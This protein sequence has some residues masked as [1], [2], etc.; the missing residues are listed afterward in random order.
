MNDDPTRVM[1]EDDGGQDNY[2]PGPEDQ[3]KHLRYLIVGLIAVIVGLVFAVIVIS[4]GD[5]TNSEPTGTTGTTTVEPS[6]TTGP[7]GV[8][9]VTPTGPT[10]DTSTTGDDPSGGV[11]PPADTGTPSTE[12]ST[13]GVVPETD[14]GSGSA[15]GG[16][17][18]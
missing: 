12:P 9:P 18:P 4:G 11:T 6:Q 10:G 13:G 14:S 2:P 1:R 7:T 8:T 15:S 5:S 16:I 17:T 3:R